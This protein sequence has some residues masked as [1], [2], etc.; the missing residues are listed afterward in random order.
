MGTA[1]AWTALGLVTLLSASGAVAADDRPAAKTAILPFDMAI[2]QQ[3]G[4]VGLLPEP[5]KLERARLKL[6]TDELGKLLGQ[7][8]R[9]AVV[10]LSGYAAEIDKASP[11]DR[12]NGCEVEIA[13]KVGADLAVTGLVQKA[14][15][16][17]LNVSIYV[18]DVASGNLTKSMAVSIRQNS[19]E[20]W[21]RAVRSLVKNRFAEEEKG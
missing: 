13:K 18:R 4:Q 9:Y 1:V 21:L 14:S 6:V 2:E 11:F 5:T 20:G 12:C 19:D 8:G 3:M 17:L 7:T 16:L 15:E 10:D